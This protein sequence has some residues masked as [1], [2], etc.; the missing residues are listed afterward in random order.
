VCVWAP[1]P[2]PDRP[3]LRTAHTQLIVE[4]NEPWDA[5]QPIAHFELLPF[6]DAGNGIN[7]FGL[8]AQVS[9]VDKD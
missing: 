7:E 3:P 4:H 5:F 1:S 8:T 6:R 9:S 2:S